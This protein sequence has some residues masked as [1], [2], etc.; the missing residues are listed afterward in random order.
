MMDFAP[1]RRK[2]AREN[3]VPM[4]NVV[5]LLLIFFLMSAQIA[6]P[7][8]VEI[9]P[10]LAETTE[11]PLPDDAQMAWLDAQGV[12]YL[13]E[14]RGADAMAA[15]ADVTGPVTLRADAMLSAA[16]FA[17]ILRQLGEAGVSDIRLVAL[18]G[19]P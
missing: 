5:F 6:P 10:P 16:D 4:I 3:V 17:A 8:P 14:M 19:A 11:T 2:P 15:L 12:L 13:G 18:S 9:M 7:D 1:P